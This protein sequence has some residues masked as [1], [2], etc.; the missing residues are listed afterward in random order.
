M[1]DFINNYVSALEDNFNTPEALAV[2]HEFLS[3]VNIGL[4]NE[5]FSV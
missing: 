4:R 2:F 3:F 1:Q 5:K